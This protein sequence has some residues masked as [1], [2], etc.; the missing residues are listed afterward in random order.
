MSWP[1]QT[2]GPVTPQAEDLKRW[3]AARWTALAVDLGAVGISLVANIADAE[4]SGIA[5]TV[6]AAPP[7]AL[8]GLIV[9]W[10]MM[11]KTVGTAG[12]VFNF[13]LVAIAVMCA[14]ESAGHIAEQSSDPGDPWLERYALAI[15]IDGTAGAAAAAVVM[16]SHQIRELSIAERSYLRDQAEAEAQAAREGAEAEALAE[17]ARAE[18]DER[19]KEEAK[20]ARR[21]ARA[22]AAA[23]PKQPSNRDR[24]HAL[25]AEGR[26][27][28]EIGDELGVTVRQVR[29]YFETKKT[30][31][32]NEAPRTNSSTTTE[33]AA[34]PVMNG[35]NQ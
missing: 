8:F 26:T 6:A 9:L 18:A 22:E 10:E 19:A 2:G 35:A 14:W 17:R 21:Q 16:S 32:T 7:L 31:T 30:T 27:D 12:R 15:V 23:R 25:R 20:Q 1:N 33:S 29:R 28:V 5:R 4:P 3:K 24:A 13:V 34:V 11:P